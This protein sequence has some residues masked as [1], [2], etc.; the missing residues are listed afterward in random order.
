MSQ[1]LR[2]SCQRVLA[3]SAEEPQNAQL[4]QCIPDAV[5]LHP[6]Q[7]SAVAHL[8]RR[9]AA[10][11][12]AEVPACLED[13]IAHTARPTFVLAAGGE[14]DRQSSP[15]ALLLRRPVA[16]LGRVPRPLV[17]FTAGALAGA[18]GTGLY[19][20]QQRKQ[21]LYDHSLPA[22]AGSSAPLGA[23]IP[24]PASRHNAT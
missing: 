21:V 10:Q 13:N 11:L 15:G 23:G 9:R 2:Y 18:I 14:A 4:G 24:S 19:R 16:A 7:T 17:L 20:A 8:H 1:P 5:P 3:A 12:R 22:C 6:P